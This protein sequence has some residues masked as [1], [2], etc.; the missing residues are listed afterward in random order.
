MLFKILLLE[1]WYHLSNDQAEMCINDSF[2]FS[3]FIELDLS[4][5]DHS[6]ICR[7]RNELNKLKLWDELLDALNRQLAEHDI[8]QIKEGEWVDATIVNSPHTPP[9]VPKF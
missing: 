5:P 4:A 6:T 1:E 8:L 7:F 3:T 9:I 2:L